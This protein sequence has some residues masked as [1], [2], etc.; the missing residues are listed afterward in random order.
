[1]FVLAGAAVLWGT[2]LQQVVAQSSTE[3]EY[4]SLAWEDALFIRNIFN[5][6][7]SPQPLL[8]SITLLEDNQ[9]A[10]RSALN[11]ESSS[12]TRH[13][14]IR[15]HLI[16]QHVQSGDI[17]LQYVQTAQQAADCLTK[18]LDRVKVCEFRRVLLGCC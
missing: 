5:E 4:L 6:V 3:A 16:R 13:I 11:L 17:R 9:S 8:K 7:S 12:R 10:M 2:K 14:D 18:A 1:M 15:H